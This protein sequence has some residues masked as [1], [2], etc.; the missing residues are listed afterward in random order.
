M[1]AVDAQLADA[2]KALLLIQ[3]GT[4]PGS[5]S[6]DCYAN[7]SEA[8]TELAGPLRSLWVLVSLAIVMRHQDDAA[9]VERY[10]AV[11]ATQVVQIADVTE[12]TVY[13]IQG[14]CS[15]DN[16]L[17]SKLNSLLELIGRARQTAAALKARLPPAAP[18]SR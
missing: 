5:P 2:T 9:T 11:I 3:K 13:G 6:F 17:I 4:P 1:N 14:I 15:Q 12:K 10:V 7:A 8:A 18:L 16:L